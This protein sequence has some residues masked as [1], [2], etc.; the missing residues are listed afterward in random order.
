MEDDALAGNR[1]F[2]LGQESV[3]VPFKFQSFDAE[4]AGT[5]G[6]APGP[7]G[8]A[9]EGL[10]L[11]ARTVAVHFVNT[12]DG[13]SA[14]VL[15]IDVR[16]RAMTVTRTFRFHGSEHDFFKA[17]LPPPPG[18]PTR[19]ADGNPCLAVRAS[20]PAV[21]AGVAE[22][23]LRGS[24]S[25]GVEGGSGSGGGAEEI[26]LRYKCG[27]PPEGPASTSFYVCV[28]ADRYL[29]QLAA[30]WRVFVH[31]MPRVDVSALVGQTMHTSIVVQ[32]GNAT[33]RVAAF[34]SH[35]DELQVAP[36]RLLL[37]AGALT[38]VQ[39][40]FRPLVH[41][42]LDVMIHLVDIE[43][44]ELVHSR[45]AATDARAPTVS[46]TFEVDLT[47]G[48][49]SHK[50][51]TYT[52]PYPRPRAF[53]LRCTHP[54]LLHFRPERLDLPANGSKPMGLTFE[55]AENWAAASR[56]AGGTGQAVEVLV[57][58]N[59]EEDATEECFRVRVNANL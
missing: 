15:H 25:A 10:H 37:P 58:I 42:R 52:N 11:R 43:R 20:D 38:E 12:E 9:D 28:Y 30:T 6:A 27:G 22:P 7:E 2:L 44:R 3:K 26:T 14:G 17:R 19:D 45:L 4:P 55:P 47:A 56:G 1:L 50:K 54:L 48:I 59:D 32:G 24:S 29:G 21:A 5:G 49:R 23:S 31:A 8:A 18:I 51:I 39:L 57:F 34:S 16:P 13:S 33:R 53:Y 36:D 46:K 41:G 35:P 40:A